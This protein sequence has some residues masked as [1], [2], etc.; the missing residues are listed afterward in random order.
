MKTY[1]HYLYKKLKDVWE[2]D[3]ALFFFMPWFISLFVTLGYGLTI[4][5]ISCTNDKLARELAFSPLGIIGFAISCFA[6]VGSVILSVRKWRYFPYFILQIIMLPYTIL[7]GIYDIIQESRC[8][9]RAWKEGWKGEYCSKCLQV[10]NCEMAHWKI[11]G[12][13]ECRKWKKV[14]GLMK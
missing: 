5:F 11:S 12:C 10:K 9:Y 2:K 7:K 1:F 3:K 14:R 13:S 6:V 8:N 4:S